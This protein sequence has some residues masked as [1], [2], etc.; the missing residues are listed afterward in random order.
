M[1]LRHEERSHPPFNFRYCTYII[2]RYN[3]CQM[4]LQNLIDRMS[5]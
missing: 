5:Y 1:N 2:L 4:A 3:F